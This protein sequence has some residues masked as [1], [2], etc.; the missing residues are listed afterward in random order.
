VDNSRHGSSSGGWQQVS[1]E[2]YWV[3]A[4][5]EAID[6]DD[7][8][9][10]EVIRDMQAWLDSP[11]AAAGLVAKLTSLPRYSDIW[12]RLAGGF[13]ANRRNDILLLCEQVIHRILAEQGSSACHDSQGFV[14]TWRFANRRVSNQPE[15]RRWLQDRI[16][17]AAPISIEMVNGLWHY[18]GNP[19]SYSILQTEDAEAV[20]QHVLD[21]VRVCVTNGQTLVARLS[22]NASATLYQLVFDPG[23]EGRHILIEVST[24]SWL[25]PHILDALR[26]GSAIAAANCGVLLGARVSGRERTT[27]DIEVLDQLFGDDASEVID[28]LESMI[29]QIPEADQSL[30]RNVVGAARQHLAGGALPNEQE[31]EGA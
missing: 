12:E 25:G 16:S 11:A 29:D 1:D 27:V 3:R 4:I 17:E 15:N 5:N 22:P 8:R 23:N 18:Y 31:G 21:T 19:G 28:I 30:V 9:D 7:V 6:A 20:R 10:Q 13:F 26:N 24:W 14:H 2:R